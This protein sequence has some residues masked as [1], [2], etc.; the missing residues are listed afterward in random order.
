[1][2]NRVRRTDCATLRNAEEGERLPHVGRGDD[3]LHVGN[4]T[5][6]RKVAYVTISHSA[7]SLVVTNVAKVIAEETEPV[8]PDGALPFV[9]KVGQPVRGLDHHR[10]RA[11][12]SPGQFDSIR[13]THISD[14]LGGSLHKG[15]AR[16][17]LCSLLFALRSSLFAP[18]AQRRAS[19]KAAF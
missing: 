3:V 6:E 4:P 10:S 18:G 14:S 2:F 17:E 5:I 11:R 12:L 13:S 15:Q 19:A 1:M 9:L 7:T 16:Q 8:S